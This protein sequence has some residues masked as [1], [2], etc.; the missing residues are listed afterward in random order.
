[1]KNLLLTFSLPLIVLT[2]QAQT[3]KIPHSPVEDF[4]YEV[5]NGEVTITS[6]LSLESTV[7][8]PDTI[9]GYPVVT[10]GREAFEHNM[11]GDVGIKNLIIPGSV[12]KICENAF[13]G[14]SSLRTIQFSE[15]LQ[16]IERGAFSVCRRLQELNLP[17][18]VVS[19]GDGAFYACSAL[20]NV[21]IPSNLEEMGAGVFE[22]CYL[23]N[24]SISDKNAYFKSVQGVLFRKSNNEILCFPSKMEIKIEDYASPF[25]AKSEK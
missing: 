6:Y 21:V 4:E 18:S 10:I 9:E 3:G 15:G 23:L 17:K 1:M 13:F 11:P 14:C 8:I 2:A 12:R 16:I 19:I 7:V 22:S 20:T 5:V 25:A 24:I